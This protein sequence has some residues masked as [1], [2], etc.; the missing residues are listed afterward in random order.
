MHEP[1]IDSSFNTSTDLPETLLIVI[2]IFSLVAAPTVLE[3]LPTPKYK[4]FLSAPCV[5]DMEGGSDSSIRS[6]HSHFAM[7]PAISEPESS[8]VISFSPSSSVNVLAGGHNAR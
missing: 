5:D 8:A 6:K 4:A 7:S 2:S 1:D 3:K